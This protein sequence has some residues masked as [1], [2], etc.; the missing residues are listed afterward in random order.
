MI[1]ALNSIYFGIFS[2]YIS[3]SG[4]ARRPI[5]QFYPNRQ[6]LVAPQNIQDQFLTYPLKIL[7]TL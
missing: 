5:T 1:S 6:R 2:A 3:F 4:I 7:D